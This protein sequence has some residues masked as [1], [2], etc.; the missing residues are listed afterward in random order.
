M[1][2]FKHIFVNYR[3]I[4]KRSKFCSIS[5]IDV[6]SR[7]ESKSKT[8]QSKDILYSNETDQSDNEDVLILEDNV[9]Y[10]DIVDPFTVGKY[11]S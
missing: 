5:E 3:S 10:V 4:K 11:Y 6:H 1:V 2:S 8:I 9:E 7:L